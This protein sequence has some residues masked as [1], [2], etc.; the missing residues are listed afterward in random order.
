[1]VIVKV[2]DGKKVKMRLYR[3]KKPVVL[4]SLINDR[5]NCKPRQN[6][7]GLLVVEIAR[8][9][10]RTKHKLLPLLPYSWC[11]QVTYQAV[12]ARSPACSMSSLPFLGLSFL[13]N[14]QNPADQRIKSQV[15]AMLKYSQVTM[16]LESH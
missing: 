3:K 9:G 5:E 2:K 12:N 4:R 13:T 7:L 6:S 16:T 11:S 1:M 15:T 14:V 8:L 10:M